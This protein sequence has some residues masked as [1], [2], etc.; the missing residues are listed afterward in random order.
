MI[1]GLA[2]PDA[3][4]IVIGGRD[5]T[6]VPP[7]RRGLGMVFQDYALFPHMTVF[8]NI[9]FGLR[10]RRVPEVWISSRVAHVLTLVQLPDAGLRYPRQLSGGQQQR[11][12]LARALAIDPAVLLLDEPLSNLDLKL[13]N[14][15]R[16]ELREIQRAVGTTT[17]FVTHDQ[18]EAMSMS[19]RIAIMRDGMLVQIGA[20]FDLYEHPRTRFVATFLGEANLFTG[21]L[22]R[23]TGGQVIRCDDGLAI[24]VPAGALDG[25]VEVAIRPEKIRLATQPSA[26]AVCHGRIRAAT[27]TGSTVR[28]HV[29]Q[30]GSRTILV[31]VP[32]SGAGIVPD[33][34]TVWL[35]WLPEH[36]VALEGTET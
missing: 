21:R 25:A 19:D 2:S 35:S 31:D 28:Y 14:A 32:Q 20:P 5:V 1:A 11:I 10:M 15:L 23:Q 12:A 9:A 34:A 17:I 6:G 4:R 29:V 3:G 36:A 8:D 13:R 33:G 16:V 7:Y 26:G 18:G 30:S 27:Y 24:P 22:E